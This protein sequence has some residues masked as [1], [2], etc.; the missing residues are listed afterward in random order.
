M[1][2]PDPTERGLARLPD[3]GWLAYQMSGVRRAP[4]ILLHRPLG[5]S[6]TLWED[7][8]ARLG[9][10]LHVV[11][12][13]PRGVGRSSDVPPLHSTRAMARD[14]VALLDVL[15]V[16]RAHV[17]GISLGGMVASWMAIEAPERIGRLVLASTPPD[18]S[19]VSYHAIIKAFDF[20]RCF[21]HRGVECEVCLVERVLS[22]RFRWAHPERVAE[23]ERLVRY[24]PARRKNLLRL[25][26]AAA[27]H[28]A[29]RELHRV[30]MDTLLVYGG[31]D[32][33]VGRSTREALL[34]DLPGAS[35]EVFP[36]AG[37]DLTLE[38]P[39]VLADRVIAFVLAPAVA[40]VNRM[41]PPVIES[42][43]HES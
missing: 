41:A 13:D 21:G 25:A 20:A 9:T 15:G 3:G 35:L 26:I 28:H 10:R 18:A 31:L 30:T 38:K 42:Q 22:R 32:P 43:G 6:M 16:L 29:G 1:L 27:R 39:H 2:R 17:F 37:H 33:L 19:S 11:A 40:R 5:G 8:A 14:A 36:D 12:F 34:H 24:V 4:P 23:I 7:F